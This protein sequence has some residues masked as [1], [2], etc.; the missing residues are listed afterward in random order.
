M[1][2][3]PFEV[4]SA[5]AGG[6]GTCAVTDLRELTAE[7]ASKKHFNKDAVSFFSKLGSALP[8]ST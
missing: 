5:Y 7:V 4:I 3:L 1:N 2:T 6:L 8:K